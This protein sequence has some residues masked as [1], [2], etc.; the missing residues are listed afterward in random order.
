[1][2]GLLSGVHQMLGN[3]LRDKSLEEWLI[4]LLQNKTFLKIKPLHMDAWFTLFSP[5]YICL[6]YFSVMWFVSLWICWCGSF[7]LLMFP[8]PERREVL[9]CLSGHCIMGYSEWEEDSDICFLVLGSFFFFWVNN[10]C[11][12]ICSLFLWLASF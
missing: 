1:M 7:P 2:D 10:K 4:V 3:C 9:C 6:C 5:D 11:L 8:Y 12:L